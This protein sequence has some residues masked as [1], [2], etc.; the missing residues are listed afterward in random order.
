MP[1]TLSSILNGSSD[2]SRVQI[3]FLPGVSRSE[4]WSLSQLGKLMFGRRWTIR[5]ST[6]R[7][8]ISLCL[9]WSLLVSI[10]PVPVP[11]A[12]PASEKDQSQPFP[13]Q[14]HPCGCRSAQQCW[15]Q[16]CCFTNEQKLAWAEKNHVEAPSFV[17]AQAL[18]EKSQKKLFPV[19]AKAKGS[20]TTDSSKHC[21]T[22]SRKSVTDGS[23]KQHSGSPR[24]SKTGQT[25]FVIGIFA[26]SCQGNSASLFSIGWA[27]PAPM[28][29]MQVTIEVVGDVPA[30]TPPQLC[31]VAFPPP[32]PPPRGV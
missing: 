17:K 5:T 16:C 28:V 8:A 24:K 32:V 22:R 18:A 4:C 3:N 14:N 10:V 15:K 26:Q 7:R 29:A 19:S 23:A 31:E 9:L 11:V 21:C 1:E 12:A 30:F 25:R 6:M 20:C 13:C 27:V 2:P